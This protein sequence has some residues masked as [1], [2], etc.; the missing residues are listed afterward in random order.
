[1]V[2]KSENKIYDL[3]RNDD[4]IKKLYDAVE[5]FENND[6]NAFG[7]H[8]YTHAVNVLNLGVNLCQELKVSEEDQE[9]FKIAALL[10]DI[11]AYCGKKNHQIRSY[12]MANEYLAKYDIE[13]SKKERILNLILNHSEGFDNEDLMVIMLIFSDKLDITKERVAPYGKLDEGMK[14]FL[15]IEKIEFKIID[16]TLNVYFKINENCEKE[17]LENYYFIPKV[18]KSIKAMA[19][20]LNLEFKIFY[21]ND[22]WN[23]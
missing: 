14:Q 9:V 1:M 10:H 12:E 16:N 21:N 2:K 20:K 15:N 11:G 19:N 18:G 23:I 7:Y 5:K 22:I 4:Y 6:P 17:K 3:I 13:K 8:N